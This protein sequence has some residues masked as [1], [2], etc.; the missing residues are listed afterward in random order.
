MLLG[1]LLDAPPRV[2]PLR[3]GNALDLIEAGDR[4]ANMARIVERLLALLGERELVLVEA[5]ALLFAEFGHWL[6]SFLPPSTHEKPSRSL[7][8]KSPGASEGKETPGPGRGPKGGGRPARKIRRRGG[9][10]R[11]APGRS[12]ARAARD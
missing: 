11:P 9:A 7:H 5:V 8:K 1:G 6:C 3:I 4:V 2:I 12:T 10:S